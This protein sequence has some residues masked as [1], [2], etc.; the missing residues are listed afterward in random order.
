MMVLSLFISMLLF[1]SA[2][3]EADIRNQSDKYIQSIKS[4]TQVSESVWALS[5]LYYDHNFLQSDIIISLSDFDDNLSEIFASSLNQREALIKTA[6][7]LGKEDLLI[8]SLIRER[9]GN[10]K[11]LL[12]D[13]YYQVNPQSH[14]YD[15]VRMILDGDLI[16]FTD[17]HTEYSFIHFL[18]IYY[19][20][21]NALRDADFIN[22]FID[23][24]N[25][26]SLN[27]LN[28]NDLLNNLYV[29]SI[30]NVLDVTNSFS[31]ISNNYQNFLNLNL[32]PYSYISRDLFWVVDFAHYRLGQFDR[33]LYVQRNITLPLSRLMGDRASEQ[34]ILSSQAAYL[35]RIGKYQ[36]AI[37]VI[38]SVIDSE[39]EISPAAKTQ[40]LN[41]LSLNYFMTGEADQYIE[42]QFLALEHARELENYRHQQ[43]IY[44]N[45]YVFHRKNQ[46]PKLALQY[47]NEAL[48]IAEERELFT[49][50]ASIKISMASYY[51]EAMNDPVSAFYYLDEADA[52]IDAHSDYQLEV[53]SA[54]E[55]AKI[56]ESSRNWAQSAEIY[57]Q[58]L[59][60]V[61]QNA[62]GRNYLDIMVQLAEAEFEM[63][64]IRQ[65]DQLIREFVTHD[66]SVLAYAIIAQA[67][68]IEARIALSSGDHVKTERILRT[69]SVQILEQARNTTNPESGF[70]HVETSYIKIFDT[71][72]SYLIENG[73]FDEALNL[74]DN[75]KTINDA[76]LIENPLVK[77]KRLSE[78]QLTLERQFNQEINSLRK[79]L[80]AS[81]DSRSLEIQ[82]RIDGLSARKR[83]LIPD[84]NK[85]SYEVIPLWRIQSQLSSGQMV[86]HV[87]HLDENLYLAFIDKNSVRFSVL[88][89][90]QSIE[91]MFKSAISG[92]VNGKTDL[93]AL[94]AVYKYLELEKVPVTANTLIVLPDSYL[95]QLPLAVLPVRA[96]EN[97]GSYG[98]TRYLIEDKRVR[99]LISLND[100]FL[101]STDSVFSHDFTGFGISDFSTENGRNLVPLPRAPQEIR[102][103]SQKLYR[104]EN[105][106]ILLDEDATTA[107]FRR[108][109]AD[110][111]ILHMATHSEIS[112]SDPL[113][114]R[115]YLH[116]GS[117]RND[118]SGQIF[119]YELFSFN[120]QNELI[121]LNSCE[122]GSGRYLQGSGIMG[123]SRAL[124]YAGARSLILNSWSVNDGY[125]SDFAVEFYDHINN[126]VPKSEALRQATLAFMKGSNA[127]PHFWGAYML[128]GDD[129]PIITKP[130]TER[131]NIVLMT[132][133]F[134]G[135]LL[136][137]RYK[138]QPRS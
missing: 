65:A 16:S 44:R 126:G 114:S 93:N 17:L 15:L 96:P 28:Y 69:T 55:R 122:S 106:N 51:Q 137:I 86:L 74:L 63:G 18:F 57:R 29:A 79:Q 117:S 76:A 24:V 113:F 108:V 75:Y 58:L 138:Q 46:N 30:L 49:D 23:S 47:L 60:L 41:N 105:R 36:D 48:S 89:H 10:S 131:T 134:A 22:D 120:L 104:F 119:A 70:W 32:L 25:F 98:S 43:S 62:D 73:R 34:S 59:N 97:A 90:D 107:S 26:N 91:N 9:D 7:Y 14:N 31:Q 6:V 68:F 20:Q 21:A 71:Y 101:G 1:S 38:Q 80:L 37:E 102:D 85:I 3:T 2:I 103:V 123:I 42:T 127:N 110:S 45:L 78:E 130:G 87:T 132:G 5:S 111:R 50:L 19:I 52:I 67:R 116:Q 13:Q 124:R 135:L 88:N 64:N 66:L 121:M 125:A 56:H 128:N 81:D 39:F 118:E 92:L 95:H 54:Y 27:T 12:Y 99:Y 109:A 112:A 40:L 33:S 136:T 8:H 72:A 53:R 77:A 83:S 82:A 129:T 100:L 35:Y 115:L 4:D 133:L 11:N 61:I 94:H 84:Q